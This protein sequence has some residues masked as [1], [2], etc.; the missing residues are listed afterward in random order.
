MVMGQR[1][2][3]VRVHSGRHSVQVGVEQRVCRGADVHS[4]TGVQQTHKAK[5]PLVSV[6]FLW[7]RVI[8]RT[9]SSNTDFP[10]HEISSVRNTRK[11]MVVIS[12]ILALCLFT[13]YPRY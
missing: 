13:R 9:N 8:V 4:D 12:D 3:V 5:K 1:G 7:I 2:E 6:P 11:K 10:I